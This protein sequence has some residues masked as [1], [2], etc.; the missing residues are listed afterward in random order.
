LNPDP[1]FYFDTASDP[2]PSFHSDTDSDP[3]GTI[4]FEEDPETRPTPHFSPD[5][6][7]PMLQNDPLR[8]PPFHFDADPDPGP[9][10]HF[11]TDVDPDLLALTDL[12]LFVNY[13]YNTS[14]PLNLQPQLYC[15]ICNVR[16]T[17][18]VC[19]HIFEKWKKSVEFTSPAQPS[20]PFKNL[21]LLGRFFT[22]NCQRHYGT[23]QFPN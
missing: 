20:L 5:L 17:Y 14:L 6:D 8:L 22:K 18:C 1:A 13:Y 23:T 12:T 2:D 10:F 7:P 9:A 4:Q 15:T 3:L 16:E 19:E 21:I 11:D